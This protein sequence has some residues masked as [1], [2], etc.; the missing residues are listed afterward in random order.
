MGPGRIVKAK[1]MAVVT[2]FGLKPNFRCAQESFST[3][4]RLVKLQRQ[5]SHLTVLRQLPLRPLHFAG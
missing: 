4:Q 5:N 3:L 2:Q 1:E